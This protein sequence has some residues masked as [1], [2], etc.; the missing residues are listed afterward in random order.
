M[1][2]AAPPIVDGR[3]VRDAGGALDVG[4]RQ[5]TP[6][7]ARELAFAPRRRGAGVVPGAW[8][9]G[10]ERALVAAAYP[11]AGGAGGRWRGRGP[12]RGQRRSRVGGAGGKRHAGGE[13]AG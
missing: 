13:A 1:F 6:T 2:R 3:E 10:A 12:P 7:V 5:D 11:A 9:A 8:V 4:A